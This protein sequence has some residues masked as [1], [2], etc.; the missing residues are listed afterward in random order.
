MIC[1]SSD[2]PS[3]W[4]TMNRNIDYGIV[5]MALDHA[6]VMRRLYHAKLLTFLSPHVMNVGSAEC[7][8]SN[9]IRNQKLI[10]E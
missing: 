7:K 5:Q 4:G 6:F 1:E 3:A 10:I 8:N 2:F 9:V